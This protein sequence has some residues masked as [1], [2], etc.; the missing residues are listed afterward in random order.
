[1]REWGQRASQ[2]ASDEWLQAAAEAGEAGEAVARPRRTVAASGGLATRAL[3]DALA[4]STRGR[5]AERAASTREAITIDA[6]CALPV[7]SEATAA[8]PSP[9]TWQS[10]LPPRTAE[11]I[12]FAKE[13]PAVA[14]AKVIVGDVADSCAASG[15]VRRGD[16]VRNA[17]PGC[18]RGYSGLQPYAPWLHRCSP[19]TV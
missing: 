15:L 3:G 10:Q 14:E 17:Y 1:M 2:A 19:S 4:G 5:K 18:N 6:N 12:W 13:A 16:Q 8:V 11:Q 7:S 9:P